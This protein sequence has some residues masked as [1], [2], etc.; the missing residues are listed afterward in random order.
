MYFF[1][2]IDRVN[3]SVAAPTMRK[4]LGLSLTEMGVIFS[5]FSFAYAALQIPGGWFADRFGPRKALAGMGVLWSVFT[6]LTAVPSSVLGLVIARIGLGVAEG[7]AFPTAT[8]AFSAW[9]PSAQRGLAQGLPHSFARLGGA[10]APPIVVGLI[11]AFGWRQS[12]WLLGIGSLL[13]VVLWLWL[14]RDRPREHP[15]VNQAEAEL[16]ERSATHRAAHAERGPT[17]WGPLIRRMWPVTLTDFCYGWSLWVF[18]TWLPSYLE[19]ARGFHLKDLAL[20]A[21]LPLLAGVVGDTLG[22]VVSD[23]IWHTGHPR[24]ARSGQISLGLLLSL[25]CVLPAALTDS[26][27]AAVWLLAASFFWLEMTNAPIWALPM[28]IGQ[29]YAGVAGGMMNTGFGVAG[30]ISPVIFGAL[31]QATGNWTLPFILSSA[32]LVIGAGMIFL[33]DSTSPLVRRP[34]PE[35]RVM[36]A[37]AQRAAAR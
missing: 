5:A 6:A 18:L 4:E 10:V 3:I 24:L 35:T 2:Y 7:G 23:S 37:E 30:I 17:P 19:S 26:P 9:I 8:R 22:G 33:A 36:A 34:A 21:T 27:I 15:R 25:V 11:L 28:D 1:T 32:L 29:E 20:F 14:Y 31:V 12:F 16:L 13:W